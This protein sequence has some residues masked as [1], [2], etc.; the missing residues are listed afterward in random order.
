M[1]T[2]ASNSFF[3]SN[4][5]LLPD[6]LAKSLPLPYLNYKGKEEYL[7]IISPPN[8]IK[9][10]VYWYKNLLANRIG[11]YNALYSIAHLTIACFLL[12]SSKLKAMLRSLQQAAAEESE[13][14]FTINGFNVFPTSYTIYMEI[15]E[16]ES[17]KK[18]SKN[19]CKKSMIS[20]LPNKCKYQTYK[21][22]ITIGKGLDYQFMPAYNL[23]SGQSY[24]QTFTATGV[25]LLKRNSQDRFET[26]QEFPFLSK[27]P[28]QISLFS[29]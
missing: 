27:S 16:I 13:I 12:D 7:L 15:K 6:Q 3:N 4:L 18:I 1:E 23:L 26:V 24:T 28:A 8:Y 22:H 5:E 29:S 25:L 21:P 10:D 17:F 14:V 19:M 2:N 11:N 20:D 9:N